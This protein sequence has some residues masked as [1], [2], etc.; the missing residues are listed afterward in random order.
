MTNETQPNTS[1]TEPWTPGPW[2]VF[3]PVAIDYRAP[4]IYG[5]NGKSLIACVEGGGPNRAVDAVE[6]RANA[7]RIV[8]CVNA[9]DALVEALSSIANGYGTVKVTDEMLSSKGAFRKAFAS[10]LQKCARDALAKMRGEDQ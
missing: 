5:A 7:Q 1:H 4:L 9:H 3:E 2:K 10:A 8:Q 6:A